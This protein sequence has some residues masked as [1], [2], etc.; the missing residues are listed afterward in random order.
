MRNKEVTVS[1][2]TFLFAI[3]AFMQPTFGTLIFNDGEEHI[4]DYLVNSDI[5]VEDSINNIPTKINFVA[6]ARTGWESTQSG[7]AYHRI[8]SYNNSVVNILGGIIDGGL[9]AYD[10]SHVFI[11]GGIFD[12]SVWARDNSHLSISGGVISPWIAA[13]ESSRINISGGKIEQDLIVQNNSYIA[14]TGG[15]IGS[16]IYMGLWDM[17]TKAVIEIYGSNFKIN[18]VDVGYGEVIEDSGR[19]SGILQNGDVIDNTFMIYDSN[20][21]IILVPEPA[22]L[23]LL[24]LG[25]IA[26]RYRRS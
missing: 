10:N 21:K 19:I 8:N 2:L 22:S 11:Q 13:Y 6:G 4:I 25:G 3:A 7:I 26:L 14:I 16:H 17:P 20:A 1:V 23:L 18:G 9:V 5:S 12:H 24:A 15:V